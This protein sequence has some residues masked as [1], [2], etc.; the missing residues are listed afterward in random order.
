M[1]CGRRRIACI[2]RLDIHTTDADGAVEAQVTGEG[3]EFIVDLGRE[4]ARWRD[5]EVTE[6]IAGSP[7]SFLD[8]WYQKRGGF[9]G[10]GV[11]EAERHHGLR[12][13]TGMVWSWI[14][15]A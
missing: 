6:T 4:L 14:A 10:T 5:D 13:S 8:S 9:A 12:G 7:M 1:T 2:W 11:G 15:L 3:L